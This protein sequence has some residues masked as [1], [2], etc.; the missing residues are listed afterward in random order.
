[1]V[2]HYRDL[3]SVKQTQNIERYRTEKQGFMHFALRKILQELAEI[4]EAKGVQYADAPALRAWAFLGM[5]CARRT[6]GPA[7]CIIE[8]MPILYDCQKRPG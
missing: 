1:V 7:T 8:C 3:T 2:L 5:H 6:G 4:R